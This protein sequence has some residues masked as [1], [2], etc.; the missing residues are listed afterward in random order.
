MRRKEITKKLL[1]IFTI[2]CCM[3]L[4]NQFIWPNRLPSS[5]NS[6]L[7]YLPNYYNHK[8]ELGL[9]SFV[10]LLNNSIKTNPCTML[11][12]FDFTKCAGEFRI[13][14][15][16]LG[17]KVKIS[18]NYANILKSITRSRYYTEHPKEACLFVP[19]LD[20]L[21]RDILS[22]DYQKLLMQKLK[23]LPYWNNGENHLIFNLYSGSHP[24]YK[25]TLNFDT[26]KAILVKASTSSEIFRTKF[27]I[28]LPLFSKAHPLNATG[29]LPSSENI[30][31]LLR[32]YWVSFKG[33]RYLKGIGSKTRNNFY[34][35]HNGKD[36][37]LLTTCKHG[38][39]W[40]QFQDQ[41]C[42]GDNELYERYSWAVIYHTYARLIC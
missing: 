8:D 36:I 32:K 19:S 24:D 31:P 2:A 20:T 18:P 41:R 17:N 22:K 35:L 26:G 4:L 10:H 3:F 21:D 30:F 27:D 6:A 28:S 9:S 42:R 13:Y 7:K 39:Y 11:S 1:Y 38:K 23:A 12:C 15:Y 16:P 14:V 37:I 33:K 29:Y 25:D 5:K 34:K 40:R